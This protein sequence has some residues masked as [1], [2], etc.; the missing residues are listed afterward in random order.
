MKIYEKTDLDAYMKEDY[1]LDLLNKYKDDK[2]FVSHKWLQDFPP[3][4][5]IYADVYGDLLRS[6]GK[7]VLDIGGGFS[8]VTRE[9]LHNHEYTLV[10]IMA[11]DDHKKIN[12]ISSENNNFW[13]KDDW[14][15]FEPEGNYDYIIAND[16]FP[17]VDQRLIPFL[18]KYNSHT[19]NLIVTLTCY[20]YDRF[21]K[22][23]RVDADEIFTMK[24]WD[25]E[26]TGRALNDFFEDM[27]VN[28][29]NQDKSKSLFNNGRII[30]KFSL[31]NYA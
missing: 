26:T 7:R 12:K 8:G 22:V 6:S 28:L 24:A 18:E 4:R 23:K 20:D 31:G 1:I 29:K 11:H 21:F 2:G 25:S 30:Y 17:N 16:I 13:S 9:F 19:G 5:M 27:K 14:A 15:D 10:D 3:K